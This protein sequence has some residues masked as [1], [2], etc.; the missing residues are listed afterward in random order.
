MKQTEIRMFSNEKMCNRIQNSQL[1]KDYTGKQGW[2]D[3]DCLLIQYGNNCNDSHLKITISMQFG[4]SVM[5]WVC[6]VISY[7]KYKKGG[8]EQQY[9]WK[10][11]YYN[12][13]ARPYIVNSG[14]RDVHILVWLL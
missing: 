13:T 14:S 2:I 3:T 4:A 5:I 1:M 6:I 7:I 10:A 11:I 9:K 12:K 8:A